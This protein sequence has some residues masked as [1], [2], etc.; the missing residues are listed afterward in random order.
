MSNTK[1]LTVSES[2]I[3]EIHEQACS[4]W[5]LKIEAEYPEIFAKQFEFGEQ[6]EINTSTSNEQDVPTIIGS[7]LLPKSLHHLRKKIII[8]SKFYNLEVIDFTDTLGVQRKGVVF[9]KQK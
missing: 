6:Y 3:K 1:K 4:D 8:V 7:G 9:T 5:K 2:F